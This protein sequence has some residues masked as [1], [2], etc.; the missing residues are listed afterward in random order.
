MVLDTSTLSQLYA[1]EAALSK[2]KQLFKF[3]DK[4][5]PSE[6][7]AT[8]KT[9]GHLTKQLL[10]VRGQT[11]VR[12]SVP[13]HS[14]DAANQSAILSVYGNDLDVLAPASIDG[15]RLDKCVSAL[16][17]KSAA[18]KYK[19]PVLA[20]GPV[21]LDPPETSGDQAGSQRLRFVF[22]TAEDT[23]VIALLP[24]VFAVPIGESITGGFRLNT[25]PPQVVTPD[26]CSCEAARVWMTALNHLLTHHN[27]RSIHL[28]AQTFNAGD[29]DL[30][31]FAGRVLATS[32][33]TEVRMLALDDQQSAYTL[34]VVRAEIKIRR[35]L[36]NSNPSAN[37]APATRP[38]EERET[39]T[40]SIRMITEALKS[41]RPK[42]SQADQEATESKL[43]TKAGTSYCSPGSR[44]GRT[45]TTTTR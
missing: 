14:T 9:T 43:D 27:G 2:A 28:D 29:L 23:P 15:T 18:L 24:V 22:D 17:P 8:L 44:R 10:F 37:P 41:V 3:L 38:Q 33:D 21:D 19:L 45:R 30:T 13:I 35:Q 16:V 11:F 39:M 5:T 4:A 1:S 40:G 26:M 6:L 12:M 36:L 7:C 20:A 32:I 42:E 25:D 34:S 31:P